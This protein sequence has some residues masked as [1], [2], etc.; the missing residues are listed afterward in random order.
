MTTAFYRAALLPHFPTIPKKDLPSLLTSII[1]T[2]FSSSSSGQSFAFKPLVAD[3]VGE[4]VPALRTSFA[5]KHLHPNTLILFAL[6]S[7]RLKRQA[8]KT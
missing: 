3:F 5:S 1:T 8:Y 7:L 2:F 4:Q 6:I